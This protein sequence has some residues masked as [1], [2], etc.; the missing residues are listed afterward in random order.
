MPFQTRGVG[1]AC[2]FVCF[3][4]FIGDIFKHLWIAPLSFSTPVAAGEEEKEGPNHV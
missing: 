1:F 4:L 3:L 2:L